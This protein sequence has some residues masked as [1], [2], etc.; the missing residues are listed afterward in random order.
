MAAGLDPQVVSKLNCFRRR[1]QRMLVGQGTLRGSC[2]LS[3]VFR[4]DQL[5][6]LAMVADR[7]CSDGFSALPDMRLLP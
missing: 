1:R 3:A 5:R 7:L 6:R 4:G 2:C